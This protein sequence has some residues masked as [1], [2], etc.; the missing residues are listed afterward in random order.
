MMRMLARTFIETG[1]DL[2]QALGMIQPADAEMLAAAFAA[3]VAEASAARAP[4][5]GAGGDMNTECPAGGVAALGA[6]TNTNTRIEG[7]GVGLS[8][9]SFGGSVGGEQDSYSLGSWG[10]S[11]FSNVTSEMGS[12]QGGSSF[13]GIGDK[14]I[15]ASSACA[16][17]AATATMFA[18]LHV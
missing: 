4:V 13:G 3:E 2:Q 6:D 9:T 18:N 15:G 1:I 7:A 10:F 11:L 8:N 16:A 17:D 5:R 12:Q 14:V